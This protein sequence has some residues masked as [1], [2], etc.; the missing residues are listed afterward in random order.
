MHLVKY[1]IP[2]LFAVTYVHC[3]FLRKNGLLAAYMKPKL[4]AIKLVLSGCV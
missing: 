4:V 3:R 2:Y 1:E